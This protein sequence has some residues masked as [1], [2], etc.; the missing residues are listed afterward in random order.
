MA[1]NANASTLALNG[2]LK[3][4]FCLDDFETQAKKHLP[5]A[6]FGYVSGATETDTAA[7]RNRRA[8]SR[9]D[10][11]PRVL[12]DVSQRTTA[13]ELWGQT[14]N[15]PIGVA[16]M[17]SCALFAYRGDLA[18]ANAAGQHHLPMIL[19]GSSLI[20]LETVIEEN[21]Q[22]WFQAYLPGDQEQIDL[23]IERVKQAQYQVLVITV[24]T[25][26]GA[27]RENNARAGFSTPLKPSL[28]LAIDGITH[29]H[30]TV[31]TFLR[32]IVKHGMPHFENSFAHRGAPIFSRHVERDF[33][34]R[35]HLN[36]T[37]IERI[38][39]NWP[40]KLVIKGILHPDD[41]A[42]AVAIGADGIIVSNHGGRQ[43][44][45]AIAPLDALEAIVQACPDTPVMLDSGIRRGTD[46]IKAI[47][48]GA[49]LVFI[50]RPFAYAAS[51]GGVTG[52]RH[53]MHLLENE[54]QRNMA[55]LGIT[56]VADISSQAHLSVSASR[57]T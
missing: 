3:R 12:T 40:G 2:R 6:I 34:F 37:H 11:V 22:A 45:Y 56:Q 19:S 28:K 26:V 53:A 35:D 47:A 43:L 38:R 18:L 16:P 30:W 49:K 42:K 32:T 25:C 31:M 21:P 15:A 8:F 33:S 5:K 7:A 24:D 10:L 23:L 54:I 48:L 29:P 51:I 36:W 41:A 17:G 13:V 46:V 27:N 57:Q 9:Y 52:V 44:D 39:K 1:Y 14:Y 55:L 20:R 50:G 4:V